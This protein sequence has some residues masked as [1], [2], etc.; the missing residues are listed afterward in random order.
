MWS[1]GEGYS[2]NNKYEG[3]QVEVK[4]TDSP[5]KIKRALRGSVLYPKIHY[6]VFE[7]SGFD[8]VIATADYSEMAT[9]EPIEE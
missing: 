4:E 3:P 1:N 8:I 7:E 9:L 5:E 6:P 2:S